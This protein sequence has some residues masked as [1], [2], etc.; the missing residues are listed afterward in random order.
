M[1]ARILLITRPNHDLIT[2]YLFH[3]SKLVIE[4]AEKK[5]I[6]VLDLQG[7]KATKKTFASYMKKHEATFIFF[8]GHGSET[9]ITGHNNEILIEIDKNEKILAKKIIYARSCNAANKLGL[10]CI[11][12]HALAF[13]GYRR[14]FAVGYNPSKITNPLKDE[15]AE[16]F[17]EPSNLIPISL[18]KGNAVKKAY[19]KSQNAMWRNLMFMLS[20]KASPSQKDAAPYLWINEASPSTEAGGFFFRGCAIPQDAGRRLSRCTSGFVLQP[21]K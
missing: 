8:N 7:N 1:T 20:T 21:L 9:T 6:K 15:I 14:K 2:S 3:W 5:G 10:S 17:I 11:K 12:H 19:E 4:E 16:L 18:L 13:I